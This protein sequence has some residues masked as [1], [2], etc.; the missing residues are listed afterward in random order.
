VNAVS[1]LPDEK[2]DALLASL[3]RKQVL[4]VRADRLSP[5]SGQYAF[6]QTL[7]R[8]VAYDMLSRHERKLRHL[9]V[10]THLRSTFPGD[11]EE[12]AEVV[13]AHYL[14]AYAAGESDPDAMELRAE[15]LAALERAARRAESVG[16][17]EAGERAYRTAL[18]LTDDAEERL[19]L[20]EAAGRMALRAGRYQE[21]IELYEAA[22]EHLANSGRERDAARYAAPIG[23]ALSYQGRNEEAIVRLEAALALLGADS[24]DRDVAEINAELASVLAFA[25]QAVRAAEPLERALRA[26]AALG[27]T[28]VLCNAFIHRGVYCALTGRLE[29][30]LVL[31]DGAIKVAER[32][33]LLWHRARA[34]LNA[35]DLC[36]RAALPEGPER[37]AASVDLSRHLGDRGLEVVA[38]GNLLLAWILVGRWD[39]ADEFIA[40]LVAHTEA[41]NPEYI[42]NRRASL[43][44]MRG[45]VEGGRAA[46]EQLERWRSTLNY[47]GLKLH[48]SIVGSLALAEGRADE[49]FDLEAA[50]IRDALTVEG[51]VSEGIRMGWADAIEAGLQAGRIDEVANLIT[52]MEAEPPGSIGPYLRAHLRRSHG[53]VGAARGERDVPEEHFRAAIDGFRAL[54]YP[55]WRARSESDLAELLIGDGRNDEATP[56]LDQAIE[57]FERLRAAPVLNRAL[58]LRA[59][60]P[61]AART[62]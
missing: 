49:A 23:K 53:L 14:E 55:Y 26:A 20:T 46:V 45:D 3:V 44:L 6:S 43:L 58:E 4:V 17:P 51:A 28:E 1:D 24:I 50:M 57:T 21:S 52:L 27:L 54:G 16:A 42:Y 35:A 47:E 29:E 2:I 25:G 61:A 11:G 5:D 18:E 31:F 30:G 33:N 32:N 7:L 8:N 13:A 59:G 60:P 19:R 56:L 15:A 40:E 9:A 38:A 22:A 34:E 10:A 41:P 12:V 39:D 36:L 48:D 37:A 62:A